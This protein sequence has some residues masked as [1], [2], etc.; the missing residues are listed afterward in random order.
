MEEV[1]WAAEWGT[2]AGRNWGEPSTSNPSWEREPAK[3]TRAGINAT[4][5]QSQ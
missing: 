4:K 2:G 1:R 5:T 3:E